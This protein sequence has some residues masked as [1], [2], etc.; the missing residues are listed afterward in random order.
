MQHKDKLGSYSTDTF[1]IRAELY[2]N[3]DWPFKKASVN[4]NVG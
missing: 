3:L 1:I 2:L 4:E